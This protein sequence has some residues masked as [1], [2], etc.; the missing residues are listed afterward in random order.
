MP[1]SFPFARLG[2]VVH[3]T[4]SLLSRAA[5]AALTHPLF[6]VSGPIRTIPPFLPLLR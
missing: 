5:G 3:G 4:S 2:A 6:Y 1:E